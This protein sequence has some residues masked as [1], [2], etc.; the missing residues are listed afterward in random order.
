MKS[1]SFSSASHVAI[2]RLRRAGSAATPASQ[3]AHEWVHDILEIWIQGA[4]EVQESNK[5]SHLRLVLGFLKIQN[6]RDLLWVGFD[7]FTTHDEPQTRQLLY[8]IKRRGRLGGYAC[9]LQPSPWMTTVKRL[10]GSSYVRPQMLSKKS[11]SVFLERACPV[12][13]GIRVRRSPVHTQN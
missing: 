4:V 5:A 7:P 2:R 6:H 10:I 1:S 8:G 11:R 9:F 12:G 13:S 3:L